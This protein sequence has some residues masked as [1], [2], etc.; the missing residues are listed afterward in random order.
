MRVHD[1]ERCRLPAARRAGRRAPTSGRAAGVA[2]VVAVLELARSAH[3]APFAALRALVAREAAVAADNLRM[4]APLEAPC[5]ALAA[6]T[7]QA[8]PGAPTAAQGPGHAAPRCV[9]GSPEPAQTRCRAR[10]RAQAARGMLQG[11]LS[12]VRLIW[13]HSSFYGSP[14]RIVALLAKVS[15]EVIGRCRAAIPLP[16]I[17]AGA[18]TDGVLLALQARALPPGAPRARA[19]R[20]PVRSGGGVCAEL[21]PAQAGEQARLT[22]AQEGVDACQHWS[23]LYQRCARALAAAAPARAWDFDAAP[24]FAHVDA[25]VQRCRYATCAARGRRAPASGAG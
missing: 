17:F 24:A 13:A 4:L 11:I 9:A 15:E 5:Q 8:C 3:L 6:A 2:A 23:A 19:R 14:E 1:S 10:A 22:R 20:R 21:R 7:P 18:A 12:Q 25:F 16:A